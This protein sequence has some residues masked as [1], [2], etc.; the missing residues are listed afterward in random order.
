MFCDK[1]IGDVNPDGVA[2]EGLVVLEPKIGMTVLKWKR[3]GS[4]RSVGQVHV[5]V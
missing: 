5:F 1:P 4:F 2:S 3:D